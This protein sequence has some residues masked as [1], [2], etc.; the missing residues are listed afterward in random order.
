VIAGLFFQF[1]A[2]RYMTIE[3]KDGAIKQDKWSG[4]SWKLVGDQWKKISESEKDYQNVD[5][6]LRKAF[7]ATVGGAETAFLL[8]QLKE[9]YPRL[10]DVSNEE[11]LVRIRSVYSQEILTRTYLDN[12]LN[13]GSRAE[14]SKQ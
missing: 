13:P 3:S 8:K 2:P 7:Q 11:L 14:D 1:Y 12:I 6:S 4:E 10:K 9:K 5:Q